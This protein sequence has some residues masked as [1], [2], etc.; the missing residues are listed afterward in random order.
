MGGKENNQEK[1]EKV[2]KGKKKNK[3]KSNK[4]NKKKKNKINKKKTALSY[5][6]SYNRLHTKHFCL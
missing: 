6:R 5:Q 3:K 1:E 4:K 2:S